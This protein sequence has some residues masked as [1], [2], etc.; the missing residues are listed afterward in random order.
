MQPDASP[1]PHLFAPIT[2]GGRTIANRIVQT[3][4]APSWHFNGL[5][6]IRDVHYHSAR[7]RG[8]LGLTIVGNRLVH[9]TSV[10]ATRGFAYGNRRRM[11]KQD[12]ALTQAVHEWGTRIFAQLNHFG[13]V[14]ESS[15]LDDYRVQWSSSARAMPGA[16]EVPFAMTRTEM[17]AVRDGWVAASAHSREAG[18]DGVEIHLANGYLLHQYISP[19]FNERTDDYGGSTLNRLRF[20]LEVLRAVRHELGNDYPV[21]I[22]LPLDDMAAA[23]LGPVDWIEIARLI[24]ND[25]D[26]TCETRVPRR[27]LVDFITVSAGTHYTS[28]A[29]IPPTDVEAGWLVERAARLKRAVGNVAVIASGAIS[30]AREAERILRDLGIDMVAMTRPLIADPGLVEKLRTGRETEIIRCIRCNQGCA[31]RGA[32]GRPITCILNPS[33]GREQ[34][35][36]R[37][38]RRVGSRAASEKRRHWVVVGGGPAGMKAAEVLARRGRRVDLFET[39]EYLGGQVIL[40]AQLP[41]RERFL[42]LVE[43]LQRS[44][45][46]QGATVH[47]GTRLSGAD[48][49]AMSPY[50]IIVATGAT[51]YCGGSFYADGSHFTR[52]MIKMKTVADILATPPQD[53]ATEL[54]ALG[55]VLVF[56]N[57]GTRIAAGIADLLLQS[58]CA[59]HLVTPLTA[60]FPRMA[61]TL[62]QQ[63]VYRKLFSSGLSF[64]INASIDPVD[65][66]TVDIVN[67]YSNARIARRRF[68]TV[69]LV[70]QPV[71]DRSLYEE[72]AIARE[73][74]YRAGDCL[75]PRSIGHAIYEGFLAGHQRFDFWKHYIEPG[76]LDGNAG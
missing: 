63:I 31:A 1:F 19:L 8:G 51:P 20:P 40:A 14:G 74:V 28:H 66:H 15:S 36:T 32:A 38:E 56:D 60:L 62:D 30:D 48:A 52:A 53:R 76:S 33:A 64:D 16:S 13:S 41:R 37:V 55:N 11:V 3:A 45:K 17:I 26:F 69:V 42:H 23:G 68:D 9:S 46:R 25:M 7:A 29:L 6:S 43:D 59:V 73:R 18:F 22:R 72:L 27:P 10:G 65:S 49:L 70:T 2:I 4:H 58:K 21:G 12:K 75:A 24:C 39:R 5:T 47:L 61:P 34:W 71:A 44:L 57:Q 50:G 35:A 67:V 54:R